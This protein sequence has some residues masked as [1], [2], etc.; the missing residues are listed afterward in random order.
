[1][2]AVILTACVGS[3]GTVG[4]ESQIPEDAVEFNGHYYLDI[5]ERKSW[6]EAEQACEAMGGHLATITSQEEQDFVNE[7]HSGRVWIG[8]Y[9]HTGWDLTW[10]WVTGEK[11]DFTYW[12]EGE[13]N[14]SSNVISN[15]TKASM[16][17]KYWNDLNI[18]SYEQGGYICEWDN[19]NVKMEFFGN[20]NGDGEIDAIDASAI[21]T[22]YASK[23]VGKGYGLTK[24]QQRMADV[25]HDGVIDAMDASVVLAYYADNATNVENDSVISFKVK[26]K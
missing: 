15:E 17:P 13:P 10:Y 14:N 9:R 1:M 22:A 18:R 26:K 19:Y 6:I 21:L 8:G 12:G 24:E 5:G 23:A 25:N 16:W 3:V 4:A 20:I 11:W 2:A 7:H